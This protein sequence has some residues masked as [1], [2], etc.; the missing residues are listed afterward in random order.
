M[1]LAQLLTSTLISNAFIPDPQRSF[2]KAKTVIIDF[3]I[4]NDVPLFEVIRDENGQ[5]VQV[6]IDYRMTLLQVHHAAKANLTG[7]E[8]QIYAELMMPKPACEHLTIEYIPTRG[9]L[10]AVNE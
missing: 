10:K 1:W 6:D 5:A 9:Y 7:D 4:G 8:Y 3:V 2:E